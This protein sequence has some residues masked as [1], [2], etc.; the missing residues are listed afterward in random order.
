[1]DEK[2]L[3]NLIKKNEGLKLDFK[4]MIDINT[5]SGKK[6]L[7]K[8]VSAIANSKGGRGYIIIGIEDK[9][10]N[11]VGIDNMDF[12]EEQIQQIISSRID[13]PVPVSL[14]VLQ[15]H[16]KK[17][18]I[19][20]IYDSDQKPYQTRENGVFYIRRGSTTDTM[21]K[22]EII[23]SLQDS[24]SLNIELCSIVKSDEKDMDISLV[25]K[26]FNAIGVLVNN[27]NRIDMMEK[28]SIIHYDKERGKFIGSLGGLLIFSKKNNIFLSH[29]RVKIINNIN[30]KFNRVNIIQGDL[31]YIIDKSK[32]ILVNILPR[33]YPIDAVCEAI[34]NAVLYRDYSI[35]YEE[36][37]VLI[38]YKSISIIS[39]GCLLRDNNM[40]SFNALKRNM[41]IYEKLISLD[42]K[43]RF[44]KSG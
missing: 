25:D 9:I 31:L 16:G 18:A 22:E 32:D 27:D 28:A 3:A 17:L 24:L 39:P 4:Q 21:R 40:S 42:D 36:I 6:E 19:I 8:D 2:K 38:D 34:N 41:W 5:E 1:M 10:K 44:T 33:S 30:K 26:Y 23:S 11:I 12:T 37:E 35:F 20:N 13:P 14:E 7:A 43:N 15:Y 29:N